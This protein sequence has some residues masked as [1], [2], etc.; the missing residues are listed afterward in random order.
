MGV[1]AAIV[2]LGNKAA[3]LEYLHGPDLLAGL[4]IA[5]VV[6][7]TV[8]LVALYFLPYAREDGLA[9]SLR[10]IGMTGRVL[11]FVFTG[12]VLI[13]SSW[14]LSYAAV[15]AVLLSLVATVWLVRTSLR[16]I[17]GCTGDVYGA[18]CEVTEAMVL[19]ALVMGGYLGWN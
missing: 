9:K 19:L 11:P 12:L 14:W 5:P 8:M 1:I 15:L 10:H 3:A 17:G 4:I 18:L 2:L 7:R 16:M 13:A 6:G